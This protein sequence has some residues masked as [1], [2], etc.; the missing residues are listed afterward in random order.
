[1]SGQE[2]QQTRNCISSRD[3][4]STTLCEA[5]ST[6]DQ[7]CCKEDN[8]KHCRFTCSNDRE[9]RFSP[10]F[11]DQKLT[12]LHTR[13]IQTLSRSARDFHLRNFTMYRRHSY[14]KTLSLFGRVL[15]SFVFLL[16]VCTLSF[17]HKTVPWEFSSIEDA[18]SND[19]NLHRG[20]TLKI[21]DIVAV[22][23]HLFQYQIQNEA[24]GTRTVHYLV[25]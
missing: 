25:C 17:A 19:Q 13:S 21:P 22:S 10:Q 5:M 16:S 11:Q 8:L 9:N 24:F 23:G 18:T 14:P 20:Y 7:C 3:S 1:M 4:S 15:L 12:L 2:S 6:P